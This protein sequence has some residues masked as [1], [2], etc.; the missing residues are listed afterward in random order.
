MVHLAC[1]QAAQVLGCDSS[2]PRFKFQEYRTDFLLC[3]ISCCRLADQT[4][5]CCAD[6]NYTHSGGC[7]FMTSTSCACACTKGI[8]SKRDYWSCLQAIHH[9]VHF[10]INSSLQ[11]CQDSTKGPIQPNALLALCCSLQILEVP[12]QCPSLPLA[13]SKQCCNSCHPASVKLTGVCHST[14]RQAVFSGLLLG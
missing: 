2:R 4:D 1:V 10:L 11:A 14:A 12:A 8:R 9:K 13:C 7:M 3:V 6:A 5:A